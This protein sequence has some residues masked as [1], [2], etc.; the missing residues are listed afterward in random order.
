MENDESP[1]GC[2]DN[3]SG[4]LVNLDD[5]KDEL[6]TVKIMRS[7]SKSSENSSSSQGLSFEN[8]FDSI[9]SYAESECENIKDKG[10]GEEEN[11]E[12]LNLSMPQ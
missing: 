5:L 12:I 6:N 10:I 8:F 9:E 4:G 3:D 11:R 1:V 2:I 7:I